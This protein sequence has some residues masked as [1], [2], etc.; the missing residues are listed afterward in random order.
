MITDPDDQTTIHDGPRFKVLKGTFGDK[1]R[2]WVEAPD[3]V[4]V[5]AYD[6]QQVYLVRQ[7]REAIGRDDVLEIPAGIMDV[8]GESPLETGKRELEEEIGMQADD[9]LHAT[10]FFS[11]SGFT[12]EQVHV[13]LAT[14]LRKV[15]EPD[16]E[17]EEG[18]ELV[19]WPIDQIDGLIDGNAD[20]KTLVGL[21]WLRRAQLNGG[22]AGT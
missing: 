8:E 17:G 15:A 3:A 18:I 20:A 11:T 13:F 22:T 7:P 10:T 12:D 19:T 9:W 6:D 5:V 2:E 16:V 21:L 4:A 14:G 1:Q